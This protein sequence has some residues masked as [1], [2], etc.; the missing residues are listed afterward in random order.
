VRAIVRAPVCDP[1]CS[2]CWSCSRTPPPTGERCPSDAEIGEATGLTADQVKWQLKKLE[3]AK[4][5]TRTRR[6]RPPSP[7]R[8]SAWSP[9]KTATGASQLRTAG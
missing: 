7:T 3:G 6:S 4:F 1:T 5:I 2:P 9:S 8:G